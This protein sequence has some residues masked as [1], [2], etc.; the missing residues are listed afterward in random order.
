MTEFGLRMFEARNVQEMR[1]NLYLIFKEAVNNAAKYAAATEVE[2]FLSVRK[3]LLLMKLT[4]NGQ[5]FDAQDP[6]SEVMG[7]GGNGLQ[8][9][10]KRAEEIGG[11]LEIVSNK[12]EGTNIIVRLRI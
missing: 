9:M 11:S 6:P 8:N 12:N 3:G 4:D 5:G 1:R 10:T 7:S 2:L